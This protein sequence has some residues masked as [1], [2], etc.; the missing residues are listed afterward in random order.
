M[1]FIEREKLDQKKG[2]KEETNGSKT[3]A[4]KKEDHHLKQK[5]EVAPMNG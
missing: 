1:K 4:P 3:K 5:Q 2:K